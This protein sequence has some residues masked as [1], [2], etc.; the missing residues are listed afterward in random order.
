M[1]ELTDIRESVR[2]RYA[3]AARSATDGGSGCCGGEAGCGTSDVAPTDEAGR[4]VFGDGALRRERDRRAPPAAVEA[5]LGCGCRPRSPIST[6]ARPSSTSA[7]AR[8]RAPT[9]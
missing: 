6:R 9:C 5:S 8:A 2:D 1:A 3:A 7:R 4:Q